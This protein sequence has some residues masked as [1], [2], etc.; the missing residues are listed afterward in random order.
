MPDTVKLLPRDVYNQTLIQNVHPPDWVNPDPAPIYNLVVIGAGTAGL[1]AAAGAAGLGARVALV[2]KEL[3]GG[4]CLNFG[5]VPS[6]AIIRS[7]RAFAEVRDAAE[8]GIDVPEGVRVN[9]PAVMERMRRLRSEISPHDSAA[10]FRELGI[11]IFLG[12]G[13]FTGPDAVEVGDHLLRF[14]KAVIATGAR[15]TAPPITGLTEAGFL[16]NETLFSLTE[17][18]GRLVVIGAGPIGCEMAQTFARFGSEV[19]LIEREPHILP[20]EDRDAAERVTQAFHRDGVHLLLNSSVLRVHKEGGERIVWIDGGKS[21]EA[22]R[23]D[24]ILVGLGRAPNLR[25][26]NLEMA[27]VQYDERTGVQVND[28]LQT[29]NPRIYAAGDVSSDFKFTHTA[30]AMA[31][32]VIQNALFKGR[33]KASALTVPWSTYTDPEIAHVGLS[34]K[35]ASQ[36]GIEVT[37]FVQELQD[38]DRAVLDGETGGLLKV[39]V[40]KGTD[41]II[42]ATLVARHAGEMISE[43]T[44]AM[45]GGLG[46]GTIAKAIHPYPTQAEAIKKVADQFN[47]SRL[48]PFVR[49]VFQKWFSWWRWAAA[50]GQNRKPNR[51]GVKTEGK[52]A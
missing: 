36:Q 14:H 13:R 49:S 48:T 23:A 6:K 7:A 8:Y 24:K 39:H 34:E 52:A 30:D 43:L 45:V 17:L 12:Q 1:V 31:R 2:E 16:T 38:V 11:D 27:G 22:I 19:Y 51:V 10:R 3:M 46:L 29:T 5:C 44:V 41:K 50:A 37:T 35:Q 33:A 32:L 4:D 26:M 18:P 42:G 15:A 28:Y 47:R 25:G 9:F 40:R 21:P 20:R